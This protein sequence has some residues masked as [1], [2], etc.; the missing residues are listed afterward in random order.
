MMPERCKFASPVAKGYTNTITHEM[1]S[2]S[3][4]YS[5]VERRGKVRNYEPFSVK[6]QYADPNGNFFEIDTV[7]DNLSTSG[8]YLR[9]AQKVH[10][11][12][13]LSIRIN[14][15][16]VSD[17][18]APGLNVSTEGEVLRVDPLRN[19]KFGVAVRFTR[20]RVL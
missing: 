7:L 19:D 15:P 8:L 3:S 17:V 12:D 10:A 1:N 18:A 9:M 14:L 20:Y 11:G 4:D 5:R 2:S 16:P 13:K 6:V